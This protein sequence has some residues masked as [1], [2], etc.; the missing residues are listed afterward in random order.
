MTRRLAALLLA[1]AVAFPAAAEAR[2]KSKTLRP[3]S[4]GAI[5][6]EPDRRTPGGSYARI[7]R[8][9]DD[10][11]LLVVPRARLR[12]SPRDLGVSRAERR[13]RERRLSISPP[14]RIGLEPTV[15]NPV[16]RFGF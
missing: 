4:P 15:G 13:F 9:P 3:Y 5:A 10:A 1:L 12:Y 6:V 14:P 16:G 2:R 8:T 7:D 11:D